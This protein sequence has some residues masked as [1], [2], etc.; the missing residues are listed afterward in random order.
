MRL[1]AGPEILWLFYYLT[2]TLLVKT[3]LSKTKAVE[4]FIQTCWF[5]VPILS[6][7]SFTLWWFP[8]VE[9]DWLLLRV[10][11]A[12]IL[13]GHFVLEKLIN[14]LPTQNSGTGM[15]YLAG[16]LFLIIFLIGGSIV[17]ALKIYLA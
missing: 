6:L 15:G 11:V 5:W 13:G 4:N 7:L 14:S 2:A 8:S 17:I 10:W 3:K 1:L 12:G 16:I 9:K